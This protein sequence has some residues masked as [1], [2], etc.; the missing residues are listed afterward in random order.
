M[1]IFSFGERKIQKSKYTH[2]ITLPPEWLTNMGLGR[3]DSVC[4]EMQEDQSL[5]IAP[6]TACQHATDAANTKEAVACQ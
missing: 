1:S 5:R 4:V 6:V 2:W 3:G